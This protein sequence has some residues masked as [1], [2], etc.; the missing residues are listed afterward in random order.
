MRAYRLGLTALLA[1]LSELTW[2][3][4]CTPVPGS[5]CPPEATVV[6]PPRQVD[7]FVPFTAPVAPACSPVGAWISSGGL[8]TPVLV[9]SDLTGTYSPAYCPAPLTIGVSLLGTTAFN[10]VATWSGTPVC[11]S[12]TEQLS[13]GANCSTASGTFVNADGSSGPDTWTRTSTQSMAI[14]PTLPPIIPSTSLVQSHRVLTHAELTV[15]VTDNSGMPVPGVNVALQS[16]RAALDTVTQPS[17]ATDSTGTARA[18]DETRDQTS[19]STIT[20]ASPDTQTKTPGTIVW[21]PAHFEPDFLVTCYVISNEADFLGTPLTSNVPGLP[22]NVRYRKGFISDV[23]L[24]GSGQATSGQIIHYDGGGTYSVQSCALTST[25]VCA[26]DGTTIAVDPTVVP[27]R[28]TV[29]IDIVG[30]RVAQD[31]GGWINGHH[32]D[33]YYGTRRSSCIAAGRRT[34]SVDFSNY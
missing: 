27:R 3:Q 15:L 28:S 6:S 24:Q 1:S 31:G 12:F 23:K 16:S 13:F 34:S 2:G 33:V 22:A 5:V 18:A 10:V 7:R 9:R 20:S 17:S 32:I 8:G 19:G 29:A 21:L 14:T 26:V 11:Q 25:G 4:V 30:S